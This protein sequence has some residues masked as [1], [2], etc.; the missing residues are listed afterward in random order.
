MQNSLINSFSFIV[1][2]TGKPFIFLL[3]LFILFEVLKCLVSSKNNQ[4]NNQ[5]FSQSSSLPLKFNPLPPLFLEF[6]QLNL[7]FIQ[8]K[9]NPKVI[10]QKRIVE[11]E[12]RIFLIK[13][14]IKQLELFQIEL[15]DN[16]K[17]KFQRILEIKNEL[18]ELYLSIEMILEQESTIAFHIGIDEFEEHYLD[19]LSDIIYTLNLFTLD[20]L[21]KQLNRFK[22]SLK[23]FE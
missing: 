11:W 5:N 8:S 13:R 21:E 1:I 22:L 3:S 19:A 23:K 15:L 12:I 18:W 2:T 14:V 6:A 7:N 9:G 10:L 4:K 17:G 16:N 20:R